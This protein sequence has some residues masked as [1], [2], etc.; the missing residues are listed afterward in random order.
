QIQATTGD[1]QLQAIAS[2][3]VDITAQ[4]HVTINRKGLTLMANNFLNLVST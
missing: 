4:G 3:S 2:R 1:A